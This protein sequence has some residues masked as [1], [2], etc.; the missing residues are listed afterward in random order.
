M[1]A[2]GE[3]FFL[4]DPLDGTRAFIKR[5]PEFTVNIGLI[6][7]RVAGV[8]HHLC[9]GARRCSMRRSVREHAIEAKI[10]PGDAA[11]LDEPRAAA[12]AHARAGPACARRLRQPLAR[13][14]EHGCLPEALRD[15]GEAQ[16]ELVAEVLPHRARRGRSLCAARCRRA[17]GTRPPVMRSS[18]A[19][20]GTRHDARRRAARLRKDGRALC[21]SAVCRLGSRAV[22]VRVR[23]PLQSRRNRATP[24]RGSATLS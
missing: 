3:P 13:R 18:I 14:G 5:S 6:E 24:D 9:A 16:G 20:G 15:C 19:A 21:Q 7:R 8:R 4:V 22:A 11:T 10:A 23:K 17:S 2:I 12:V 1:P